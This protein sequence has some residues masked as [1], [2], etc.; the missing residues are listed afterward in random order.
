MQKLDII[1][2]TANEERQVR[3]GSVVSVDG[4]EVGHKG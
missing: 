1:M 3:S 2:G 4:K